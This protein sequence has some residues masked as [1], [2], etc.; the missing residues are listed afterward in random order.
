MKQIVLPTDFS[1]NAW[2]A[3]FTAVKI[4]RDVPCNFHLMNT[5]KPDARNLLGNQGKLRLG[6]IYSSLEEQSQGGLQEVLDYMA[7]NHKNQKHTFEK[8]SRAEHLDAAIKE[9]LLEKD[10]DAIVMGTKGATGAKEIFLGSN[11]VKVIKAIRNRP[12]IAVPDD[13]NFQHL[14]KVIF[15]TD[16]TRPFETFELR[17]LMELA[18]SWN[19]EIMIVQVGQ[20]FQM[21]DIQNSTKTHLQKRLDSVDHSFHQVKFHNNIAKSISEFADEK[22][23]DMIALIH[24]PHSFLEKLVRESVISKVAFHTKI[25]LLV[26]PG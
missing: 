24:Y 7:K 21:S 10:I 22:Q 8:I 19:S 12:I 18:N 25:P 3:L 4:Y 6:K 13:Y 11:T 23:S 26:L 14:K 20:E 2:N 5:H 17:P 15:P 1:D 16:F 9:I